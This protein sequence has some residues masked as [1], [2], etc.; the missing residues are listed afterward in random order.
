VCVGSVGLR[1][2]ITVE[3]LRFHDTLGIG[4]HVDEVCAAV[5]DEHIARNVDFVRCRFPSILGIQL[6]HA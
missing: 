5:V 6:T 2:F 1:C 4:F 3:K